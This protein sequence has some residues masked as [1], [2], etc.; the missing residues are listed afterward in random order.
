MIGSYKLEI[1]IIKNFP[2]LKM[3]LI[4]VMITRILKQ[5]LRNKYLKKMNNS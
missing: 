3:I 1:S 5:I 4:M 2:K